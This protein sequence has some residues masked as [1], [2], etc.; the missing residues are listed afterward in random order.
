MATTAFC[1]A[2]LFICNQ[3]NAYSDRVPQ[4]ACEDMIPAGHTSST[5]QSSAA[6]YYVNAYKINQNLTSNETFVGN[7][8]RVYF[9]FKA[10]G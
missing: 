10:I 8:L 3:V 9:I 5:P 6:P 4:S 2:I 1:F 7:L